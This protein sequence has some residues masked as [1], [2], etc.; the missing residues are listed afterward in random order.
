MP[1]RDPKTGR[2][3]K[4][5]TLSVPEPTGIGEP[6]PPSNA[7]RKRRLREWRG[8]RRIVELDVLAKYLAKCNGKKCKYQLDLQNI[9]GKTRCGFGSYLHIRCKLR[10][11]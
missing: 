9:V 1:L 4:R 11:E 7:S 10:S 2:F 5:P 8:G 6:A 3:V